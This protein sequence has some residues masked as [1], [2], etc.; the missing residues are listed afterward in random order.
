MGLYFAGLSNSLVKTAAS[1]LVA[2]GSA[3]SVAWFLESAFIPTI[4]PSR[5]GTVF[6]L[7]ALTRR[8]FWKHFGTGQLSQALSVSPASGWFPDSLRSSR[9]RRFPATPVRA[10]SRD[11]RS[12]V[13]DDRNVLP[14][15]PLEWFYAWS[16]TFRNVADERRSAYFSRFWLCFLP[17]D[18]SSM[19]M[20]ASLCPAPKRAHPLAPLASP[21]KHGQRKCEGAYGI[22]DQRALLGPIFLTLWGFFSFIEPG[23]GTAYAPC[24]PWISG[25]PLLPPV[26][27]C[28]PS[29]HSNF[30]AIPIVLALMISCQRWRC[31]AMGFR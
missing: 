25:R 6:G 16:T 17:L 26:M 12:Q 20:A 22:V 15:P 8:C 13:V 24:F 2:A 1:I 30:L 29:R 11:V 31:A 14:L 9:R 10:T 7:G 4:P 18:L 23:R 19:L 3:F 21:G 28:M 5:T 27:A